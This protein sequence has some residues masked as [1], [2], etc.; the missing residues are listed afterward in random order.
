ML[1]NTALFLFSLPHTRG[2][3]SIRKGTFAPIYG[4]S[5]HPWGCFQAHLNYF[6]QEKVFPTPVGVFLRLLEGHGDQQRLPH[7]RGGVSVFLCAILGHFKSSPH[8]WGCFY[9]CSLFM[10]IAIVFPTP[11]GVFLIPLGSFRVIFSLPH[12]RGGVSRKSIKKSS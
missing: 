9:S 2:G 5:P 3:V 10:F 6:F 1:N 12:T 8:P 4:S 7:T 11:V